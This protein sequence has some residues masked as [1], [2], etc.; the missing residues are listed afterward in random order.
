MKKRATV[1][2]IAILLFSILSLACFADARWITSDEKVETVTAEEYFAAKSEATGIPLGVLIEE[3]NVSTRST[4]SIVYKKYTKT[5]SY[6]LNS[7]Y[8]ADLGAY[9]TLEGSGNYY[10]I[11]EC[12]RVFTRLARGPAT[13]EWLQ[14]AAYSTG[15]SA[16]SCT[17]IGGGRFRENYSVGGQIPQG[18]SVSSTM[19]V[20][21]QDL[22]MRT[23]VT[24]DQLKSAPST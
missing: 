11:T 7:R 20:M 10:D 8:K 18:F 5:F 17:L 15:L 24:A 6:S 19:Y 9:F 23:T 12:G 4:N 21:S 13:C 14:D 1:A 22:N 16:S 2:I 3:E